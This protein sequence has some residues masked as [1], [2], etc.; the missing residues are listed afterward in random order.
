MKDLPGFNYNARRKVLVLDGYVRGNRKMRRQR[1][2]RNV[3]RD[4]ALKLWKEFRADLDSGRAIEGPLTLRQFIERFYDRIAASHRDSTRKTQRVI[5]QNHLL[6]YFGDSNLDDITSI[7]VIDFMAD[8]RQRKL[9]GTYINN[10]VR[11]L[12]ML[13]R[14]AVERDVLADYPIKKK[15][16]KEKE[17]PLRQELSLGERTR[18]FG[19]FDDE[20][21]FRRHLDGKRQL[22]P[23]KK[24]SGFSAPRRFGGGLRGD[25]KAAGV[26]FQRFQELRDFFVAAV[27]TGLRKNDLRNLRWNQVDFPSGFIRVL[28]QK[29]TLEAEIP[30]SHACREALL[31]AKTRSG[32]GDYVFRDSSGRRY[33]LTRIRRVFVLA[34]T[35]AAIDR[36]FR[37]HDLRHTFGCRLASKSVGLQI[38]A[39]AL[40]HTTTRM[41][42]RYAR[43]SDEAMR[44]VVAALD[45]DPLLST[46]ETG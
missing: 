3:T 20:S 10:A 12:K 7:R 27:E 46:S 4:Q 13:L 1:T 38:I 32:A 41:A 35:L 39:K 45:D 5:I 30:I 25:S 24:G 6:R 28:M 44:V 29:T 23:V 17:K 11:V 2:F 36:P 26:A 42:E 8:M 43:P 16:P 14:Q 15:I 22:G 40:G 31:S 34:K 18:F 37:P 21:V 33:S 9:S 19:V